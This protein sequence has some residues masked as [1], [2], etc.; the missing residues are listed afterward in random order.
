MLKSLDACV[1]EYLNGYGLDMDVEI[2][3]TTPGAQRHQ[4]ELEMIIQMDTTAGRS[5]SEVI[6]KELH[7]N[8]G[9][10]IENS[11]IIKCV[12]S[13]KDARIRFLEREVERLKVFENYI[14]VEKSLRG[15]K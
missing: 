13:D 6:A 8:W 7:N 1:K 2:H 10:K 5:I 15:L 14:E 4:I 3:Q 11:P 9:K 12:M